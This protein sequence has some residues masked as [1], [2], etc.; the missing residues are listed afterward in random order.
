MLKLIFRANLVC[1]G[2]CSFHIVWN[3]SYTVSSLYEIFCVLPTK[4]FN[5]T[6]Y[7]FHW[8]DHL[9]FTTFMAKLVAKI[10]FS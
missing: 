8:E 3:K 4:N 5:F 9:V 10:V 2:H 6:N 1:L 7:G